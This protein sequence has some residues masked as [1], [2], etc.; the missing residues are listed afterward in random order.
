VFVLA[1][2]RTGSAGEHFVLS[3]KRTHRATVIGETTYGAGNFGDTN[4][5]AGGFSAFI[6][7]GRTF[8]P[9]TGKGWDYVGVAPDV[10]VP[11]AEAL[12]EALVRSGIPKTEAVKLSAQYGPPAAAVASLRKAPASVAGI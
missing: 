6:P 3:L 12:T 8:D 10:P 11:A 9:D 5:I 4:K 1:S 2:G 7:I